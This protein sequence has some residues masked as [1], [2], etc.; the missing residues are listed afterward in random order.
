MAVG[1]VLVDRARPLYREQSAAKVEGT[2]QQ[3]FV[4]GEWFKA[5]LTIPQSTEVQEPGAGRRRVEVRPTLMFAK[6]DVTGEPV[7]LTVEDR[8]E[9]DSKQ[10]GRAVYL[11]DGD[12]EPVRKRRT[13]NHYEVTIRRIDDHE[14]TGW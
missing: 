10:L 6:R 1:S 2:S 8:I 13:I 3:P 9:V 11:L 7:K 4:S 14:A 12:P 5:R